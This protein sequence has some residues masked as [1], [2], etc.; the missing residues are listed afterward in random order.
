MPMFYIPTF[1]N[2]R[3]NSQKA[4]SCL[5]FAQLPTLGY[6]S[7]FPSALFS[8]WKTEISNNA[9]TR[10]DCPLAA[11]RNGAHSGQIA[12]WQAKFRHIRGSAS[13]EE[14]H[15]DKRRSGPVIS[16]TRRTCIPSWP[17]SPLL[18]SFDSATHQT[19]AESNSGI[20]RRW[21]ELDYFDSISKFKTMALP[22]VNW[23]VEIPKAT[24]KG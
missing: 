14:P 11:H 12:K 21:R 17:Q 6:P 20:A 16:I 1:G 10:S 7:L 19:L 5:Y 23:Q 2:C 15:T 3:N 9:P 8:A 13:S 22:E 24:K 4:L 18:H